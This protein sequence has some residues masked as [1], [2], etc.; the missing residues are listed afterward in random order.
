ML[1]IVDDHNN[2]GTLTISDEGKKLKFH[3]KEH[4]SGEEMHIKLGLKN[5]KKLHDNLNKYLNFN[6]DEKGESDG[7]SY[8]LNKNKKFLEVELCYV[9]YGFVVGINGMFGQADWVVI[10]VTD[11]EMEDIVKELERKIDELEGVIHV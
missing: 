7:E 3:I 10:T 5:I 9:N 2:D 4:Q 11:D 8:V 1:T 6:E